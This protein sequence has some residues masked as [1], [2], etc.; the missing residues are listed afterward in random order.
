MSDIVDPI[1]LVGLRVVLILLALGEGVLGFVAQV[2]YP[3]RSAEREGREY[4]AGYHGVMQD[5][6]FYNLAFA[7]LY[8]IA[9]LDPHRNVA[10]IAVAIVLLLLHGATHVA[11]YFGIYYGGGT[12]IP[13][14]PTRRE[15]EQG[16][17]LLA[18]AAG[19]VI[20]FP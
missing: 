8:G 19:L 12:P 11:R 18:A 5:F 1:R 10:V 7:L 4:N 15:L 17:V 9:A 3:Q 2:F 13:G 6:G 20:F 16:L 14:R